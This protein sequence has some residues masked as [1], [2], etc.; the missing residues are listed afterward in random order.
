MLF[1][2]MV[3][4]LGFLQVSWPALNFQQF[5]CLNPKSCVYKDILQCLASLA[6]SGIVG[7]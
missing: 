3:C 2:L 5:F 4:L 1:N 7:G 6:I